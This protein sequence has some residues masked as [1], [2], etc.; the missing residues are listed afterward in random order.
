MVVISVDSVAKSFGDRTL[1]KDVSFGLG[2]DD[3]VGLLGV[4]G[5]GKTT[6]LR[7]LLELEPPDEGKVTHARQA[8][9]EYLPQEPDLEPQRT[10]LETVIAD[11]P[12]AF[13]V[14]EAYEAACRALATN[15]EDN[16]LIMRVAELGEE[17]DRVG[18]WTLENEA[19]TI[20]S[21][22]GILNHDQP[23]GQMSGGQ[24]KRVAMARSLVRPSDLLI[25]DE[26]TNHLD[27]ETVAWLEDYL[28]SRSTG[29]LLITHDRYFL[30]RV[31]NVILELADHTVYRHAGN[32]SA[33]LEARA[34]REELK[35][36]A[37]SKRA[38][39]AK[40]E[41]AWLRR[42]P[43]ARTTK[44]KSRIQRAHALIDGAVNLDEQ[45]VE[46]DTVESRLGKK[47]IRLD[48]VSHAYEGRTILNEVSYTV[49]RRD[50]LG[51]VGPNGAG[52]STLLNIIADR[53][54]PDHGSVDIG[55]TVVIGY[56]DQ[57]A[58]GLDPDMRV[59]DYI[60]EVAHRIPT[61]DGFLT[62][63][64]MLDL[65][66]FDRDKQWT[67]IHKLSGGERRR[68][69]LLRILMR[70]P[71]VLLL[72]EPTNDLDVDT[73]TV[74][75]DYLDSF[76]GAVI[77]VSHDRYFLD[78]TCE[79]LLTFNEGG[80]VEEVP[81]N[82]AFLEERRAQQAR[83]DRQDAAARAEAQRSST[84]EPAAP[85]TDAP[86]KLSYKERRELEALEPRIAQIEERLEAIDQAMVASATDYE[87]VASLDE[88]KATLSA[89]L[90]TALERWMELSELA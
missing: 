71:N 27:I 35:H 64:Q 90:E 89:E 54:T 83:K 55:E 66:L 1:F 48:H 84:P 11:G 58:E 44:S 53:L 60:T 21:Q 86:R 77:T 85:T 73:L 12:Q 3:R 8:R 61:S 18:G 46:I 19:K 15:P 40:K 28:A 87:A 45:K 36:I 88:E 9:I 7:I 23:V 69:Y 32:Y 47:I 14:V 10:A 37:E 6:L 78:R 22:L 30:D 49:D 43:K 68:L 20:L 57:Q 82:Y 5:A 80:N 29:L 76:D 42:G 51:I 13:R 62:A 67:Y 72:D 39:L 41:L 34:H 59:H 52:K 38:Q 26:P 81:G 74:L 33:F 70:Q 25:L 65:F 50:R 31:A 2:A 63:S 24:Q 56:F 75:E 16:D 17:M 4:N 79:H